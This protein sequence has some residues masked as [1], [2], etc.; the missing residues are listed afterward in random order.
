MIKNLGN[1]CYIASTLQSLIGTD[2]HR[3]ILLINPK[4]NDNSNF[5]GI[6][7]KICEN[8]NGKS[9][10]ENYI[11]ILSKLYGENK[12]QHDCGEFYSFIIEQLYLSLNIHNTCRYRKFLGLENINSSAKNFWNEF[13]DSSKLNFKNILNGIL[14]KTI[15]CLKC[16]KENLIFEIIDQINLSIP[17]DS[18][19]FTLD[20]LVKNF[21]K[22]DQVSGKCSNCNQE[23]N[24]SVQTN[25]YK[26]PEILVFNTSNITNTPTNMG[27]KQFAPKNI[28]IEINP[29][30]E[31]FCPFKNK[32]ISYSLHSIN[33]HHG[34]NISCG[35]ST[36]LR[37]LKEKF[38]HLDD[39]KEPKEIPLFSKL[40]SSNV[41]QIFYCLGKIESP[42]NEHIV[43]MDG[44]FQIWDYSFDN[45]NDIDDCGDVG[46]ISP[47]YHDDDDFSPSELFP[48]QYSVKRKY[49]DLEEK[50]NFD[51]EVL[52]KDDMVEQKLL[53]DDNMEENENNN[54]NIIM[55]E[56][57]DKEENDDIENKNNIMEEKEDKEE[58]DNIENENNNN[59]EE[60]EGEES[61]NKENIFGDFE[62]ENLF[63]ILKD[64]IYPSNGKIII[65]YFFVNIM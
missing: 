28:K 7:T 60:K 17:Y 32:N 56:K 16:F 13:L 35:H 12:E 37:R 59:M 1:T 14:F 10:E 41:S 31:F 5:L 29:K 52:K 21:E 23:T 18:G 33:F 46:G 47:N 61:D 30:C 9:L 8:L 65:L 39:D 11:S 57:D 40:T 38:L 64:Q 34:N 63:D 36:N 54:K 24:F 25:I 49:E 55:E 20:D 26:F 42:P 15:Q 43:D 3:E 45:Q 22:K 19:T 58:N 50:I 4:S 6:I 53:K 48:S 27:G 51:Y 44:F 2:F 62:I